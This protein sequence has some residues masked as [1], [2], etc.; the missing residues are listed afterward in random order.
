MGQSA[1][2][3]DDQDIRAYDW[4][5]MLGGIRAAFSLP[6]LVMA[7][8]FMGFG[9][10]INDVGFPLLAGV[11]TILLIWALPGQVLFVTLWQSGVAI[12]LIAA[13]VSLTAVRLL[14][15]TI[16]VLAQVRLKQAAR[17][18]EFLL[19]HFTAVT[20]WVLSLTSL[21]DVS[22]A[23]QLPWLIGL[24][25][26]LMALMMLVVPTGYYLADSLPPALAAAMVF[27]TPAFFLLSL[28]SGSIWR[29]DY[30]AIA[31]G[32]V[33]LPIAR[34]YAADFDLLIAGVGGGT[35]AFICF[36]PRRKG[37]LK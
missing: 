30:A 5:G 4:T 10:L 37:L 26:A 21:H 33:L 28:L 6:G 13:A 12:P 20:V 9:A 18:P 32:C 27:F 19:G 34:L 24:G 29:F 1:Q 17:A 35:L 11:A 15:M 3:N 14:P 22:A 25:C 7:C 2:S 36:R 31:L 23:R 16:G 8:S